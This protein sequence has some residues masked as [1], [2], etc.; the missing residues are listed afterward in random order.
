MQ[1]QRRIRD[2]LMN[3]LRRVLCILDQP[4]GK[5]HMVCPRRTDDAF[6]EE[7]MDFQTIAKTPDSGPTLMTFALRFANSWCQYITPSRTLVYQAQR[8]RRRLTIQH[9]SFPKLLF[10]VNPSELQ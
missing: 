2:T 10:L 9:Y 1:I 3:I 4:L 7:V 5:P 6:L 8:L